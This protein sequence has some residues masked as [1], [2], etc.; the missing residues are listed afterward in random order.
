MSVKRKIPP[1]VL[2]V[3]SAPHAPLTELWNKKGPVTEILDVYFTPEEPLK[4]ANEVVD[5]ETLVDNR[6]E[7][8]KQLNDGFD[9]VLEK[10]DLERA[11]E[12]WAKKVREFRGPV[13]WNKEEKKGPTRK[14]LAESK[15]ASDIG[16]YQDGIGVKRNETFEG[17]LEPVNND[18]SDANSIPV[19][20]V[21][22]MESVLKKPTKI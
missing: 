1:S 10:E 21:V 17:Y 2:S 9:K 15:E 14:G 13:A 18:D 4:D 22:K 20:Y 11:C 6:E 3:T 19:D 7:D 5:S 12:V 16:C 8:D